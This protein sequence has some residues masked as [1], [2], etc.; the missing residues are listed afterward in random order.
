MKLTLETNIQLFH[1]YGKQTTQIFRLSVVTSG[2]IKTDIIST[3]FYWEH[4]SL[5]NY[6][7][8]LL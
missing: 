5:G 7:V 8:C 1:V 6:Y 3:C 2:I 4:F